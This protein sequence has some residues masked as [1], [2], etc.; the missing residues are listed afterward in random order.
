MLVSQLSV[1]QNVLLLSKVFLSVMKYECYF[2]ALFTNLQI[3]QKYY[4]SK[5]LL[6]WNVKN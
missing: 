4:N 2:Y 6:K 3:M 1:I 5:N